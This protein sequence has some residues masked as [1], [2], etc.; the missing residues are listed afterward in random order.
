M[1][2]PIDP[3]PFTAEG[4][5]PLLREIPPGAPYPVEALGPL[6]AVVEA[7]HDISQAPAAIAAQSALTVASF[8][9]QAF[10]NVEI[11]GTGTSPISLFAL[12]VA[13]SGERKS[14]CDRLL[15]QGAKD[16]ERE[17][18]CAYGS[19][20]AEYDTAKDVWD[21]RHKGLVTTISGKTLSRRAT[22]R[23][24][25][26]IWRRNHCPLLSPIASFRSRRSK[27]S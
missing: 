1:V 21:A 22:P 23:L 13:E 7:V 27:A 20:S 10:A 11:L 12:T 15:M 17:Q 25:C 6:R 5:Q 18:V 4:P 9:T 19:A 3:V 14:T 8:A 26:G 2:D 24:N 16:H